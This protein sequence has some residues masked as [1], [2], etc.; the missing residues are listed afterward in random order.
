GRRPQPIIS[1]IMSSPSRHFSRCPIPSGI[2]A[3]ARRAATSLAAFGESGS[4]R[5]GTNNRQLTGHEATSDARCRLTPTWQLVTFPAVPVYWRA[6]HTDASPDFRKPVSQ[7]PTPPDRSPH[8]SCA[9]T[10]HAP[11]PDPTG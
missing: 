10:V 4:H 5:S 1:S 7:A 8:P 11:V 6:T 2:P 3:L 9:P